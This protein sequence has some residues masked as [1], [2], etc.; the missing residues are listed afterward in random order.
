MK[1]FFAFTL[2]IYSSCFAQGSSELEFSYNPDHEIL[3]QEFQERMDVLTHS[4]IRTDNHV[5]LLTHIDQSFEKKIEVINS[6]QEIL[7]IST[8]FLTGFGDDGLERFLQA[9]ITKVQEGVPV[10]LIIDSFQSIVSIH[11]MARLKKHGIQIAYYNTTWIDDGIPFG[12]ANHEKYVIADYQRAVIGGRNQTYR[13]IPGLE[14]V[15]VWPDKDVYIEGTLAADISLRFLTLWEELS[16]KEPSLR[17][18]FS[19]SDMLGVN[20]SVENTSTVEQARFLYNEAVR[21][22]KN[23][24]LY[25]EAVIDAAQ[26]IIIWQGNFLD[27]PDSMVRTLVRASQRGVRV[28]LV[29]NSFVSGWWA[30]P[31]YVLFKTL[32]GSLDFDG[33][34]VEVL[35]YATQYN[36]SKVFYVDGVVASVGSLNHDYMSIDDDSEGTLVS[37]DRNFNNLVFEN[38][39]KDLEDT[40]PLNFEYYRR[41]KI[42]KKYVPFLP[43]PLVNLPNE[44][45]EREQKLLVGTGLEQSLAVTKD[46]FLNGRKLNDDVYLII[47]MNNVLSD[48][49]TLGE[50]ALHHLGETIVETPENIFAVL[51]SQIVLGQEVGEALY[52]NTFGWMKQTMND[53]GTSIEVDSSGSA[54]LGTAFVGVAKGVY[55]IAIKLPGTIA[56]SLVKDVAKTSHYLLHN[57]LRAGAKLVL[58]ASVLAYGT[59]NTLI[60]TT[61]PFV[62]TLYAGILTASEKVFLEWP[63]AFLEATNFKL[64]DPEFFKELD[65]PVYRLR[66]RRRR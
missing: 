48:T 12:P 55:Y 7:L 58:T 59:V 20:Q 28:I 36:H 33:T 14:S 30:P 29:T 31:G 38:I 64:E 6:A 9:M 65:N 44:E 13:V 39:L 17:K 19:E 46:V 8:F 43:Y 57:P 49:A 4:V 53:I 21:G 11:H 32:N 50:R 47:G 51:D 22:E 61:F 63:K 34:E 37:Y 56:F 66:G 3:S 18:I 35:N 41:Y 52:T 26:D 15:F 60:G 54:V 2:F 1:Y 5:E 42:Y 27:L 10:Y 25:Y 40:A 23:I 16:D 24:S 45:G 62:A